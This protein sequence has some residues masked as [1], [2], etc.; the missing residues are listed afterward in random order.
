MV[1]N[2]S[3]ETNAID[4]IKFSGFIQNTLLT[5]TLSLSCSWMLLMERIWLLVAHWSRCP[6]LNRKLCDVIVHQGMLKCVSSKSTD[7]WGVLLLFVLLCATSFVSAGFITSV[8]FYISQIRHPAECVD[9]SLT[10]QK[11]EGAPPLILTSV[12]VTCISFIHSRYIPI[13]MLTMKD[14]SLTCPRLSF[15]NTFKKFH[16]ITVFNGSSCVPSHLFNHNGVH[17]TWLC[18][19]EHISQAWLM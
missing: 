10:T 13:S 7:S 16:R 19:V 2:V 6:H 1:Q 18:E 15:M 14:T 9:R 8:L 5:S 12:Y 11:Q 4:N 3:E 17:P